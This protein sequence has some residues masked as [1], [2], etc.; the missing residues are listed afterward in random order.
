MNVAKLFP[1][2]PP[3]AANTSKLD[4]PPIRLGS[5]NIIMNTVRAFLIFHFL[6]QLF[7]KA[8]SSK[9]PSLQ[10]GVKGAE[11]LTL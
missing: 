10:K 11:S 6:K 8:Q 7:L 4:T 2:L 3:L 5:N 9:L 1:E